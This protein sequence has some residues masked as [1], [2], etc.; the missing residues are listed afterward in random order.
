MSF[1]IKACFL[2]NEDDIQKYLKLICEESQNTHKYIAEQLKLNNENF[3]NYEDLLSKIKLGNKYY[4]NN[5]LS[6]IPEND[7]DDEK[8]S[9]KVGKLSNFSFKLNHK[10]SSEILKKSRDNDNN[11]SNHNIEPQDDNGDDFLMEKNYKTMKFNVFPGPTIRNLS[12]FG[13][14]IK[15]FQLYSVKECKNVNYPFDSGLKCS[16][17]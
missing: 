12:E 13:S 1:L 5:E 15:N 9:E 6:K 16:I 10:D 4:G 8:I 14:E 11:E 7:I 2:N 17:F 3:I